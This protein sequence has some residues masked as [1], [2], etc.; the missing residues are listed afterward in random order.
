ME[1]NNLV[2]IA[3]RD[4]RW[5]LAAERVLSGEVELEVVIDA[6]ASATLGEVLGGQLQVEDIRRCVKLANALDHEAVQRY[7]SDCTT[8]LQA[9]ERTARRI[10]HHAGRTALEPVRTQS[11]YIV[12]RLEWNRQTNLVQ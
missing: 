1:T 10:M 8:G 4:E 11:R 6:E 7:G 2:E 12:R 3:I 9:E 5:R